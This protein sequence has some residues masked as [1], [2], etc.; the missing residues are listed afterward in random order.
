MLETIH[1][2][3]AIF[4]ARMSYHTSHT[5]Y[6]YRFHLENV[7][8]AH[9]STTPT[10]LHF[11]AVSGLLTWISNSLVVG[12]ESWHNKPFRGNRLSDGSRFSSEIRKFNNVLLA[13]CACNHGSLRPIHVPYRDSKLT[14]L[15][16]DTLRYGQVRGI[17]C[18]DLNSLL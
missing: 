18:V 5:S 16:T 13:L 15:L 3:M 12:S 14:R 11:A 10:L 1:H 9:H 7:P 6:L 4:H 17:F 2:N 8:S